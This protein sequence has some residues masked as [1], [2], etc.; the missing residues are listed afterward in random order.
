MTGENTRR[1]STPATYGSGRRS[2]ARCSRLTARN[3]KAP[4]MVSAAEYFE[5][6][7]KPAQTPVPHQYRNARPPSAG[8]ARI[9]HS[10]ALV[11]A[12]S[13]GPSGNTQPP[14]VMPKT[15]DRLSVSAAQNPALGP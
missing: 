15:G 2:H 7:A 14:L 4:T 9:R 13:N 1:A 12:Q 11:N 8:K 3:R 6:I 5:N 10:A